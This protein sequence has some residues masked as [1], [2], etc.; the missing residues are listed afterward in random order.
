MENK[1]LNTTTKF[2]ETTFD[3][4]ELFDAVEEL[5]RSNKFV[6]D[7]FKANISYNEHEAMLDWDKDEFQVNCR[8]SW[9]FYLE[10]VP[11]AEFAKIALQIEKLFRDQFKV[12]Y[13]N[14][15]ECFRYDNSEY[16]EHGYDVELKLKI[17]YELEV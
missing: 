8:F 10:D 6:I 5:L 16:A 17:S 12:A 7:D 1:Y 15:V 4:Q 11:K 13:E 9:I 2:N 3:K 14:D